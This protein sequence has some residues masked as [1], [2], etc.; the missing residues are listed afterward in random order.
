MKYSRLILSLTI[1]CLLLAAVACGAPEPIIE[2]P[3]GEMNF[4]AADLGAEWTME[5]EQGLNALMENPPDHARDASVRSFTANEPLRVFVSMTISTN[6]VASAKSEMKGS[7][8]QDIMTS[9]QDMGSDGT[10][11]EMAAPEI[12]DETIMIGG[13]TNLSGVGMDAYALTFRKANVIA[14]VF[15]L[16]PGEFANEGNATDYA[17]ELEARIQ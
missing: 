17:Q 7:F 12:G 10:F 8:V 13:N 9:L 2:T 11:E 16:G 6:S 5:S 14:M 15:L 4:A 3:A 1:V